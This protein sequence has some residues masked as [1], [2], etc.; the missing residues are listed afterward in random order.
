MIW[1]TIYL[2]TSVKKVITDVTP[3]TPVHPTRTSF[4]IQKSRLVLADTNMAVALPTQ[5]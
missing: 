5:T 2:W 4:P 3:V 1:L